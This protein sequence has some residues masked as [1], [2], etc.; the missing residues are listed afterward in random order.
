MVV[1]STNPRPTGSEPT[2]RIHG[3]KKMLEPSDKAT[4][5]V[6]YAELIKVPI[7]QWLIFSP[8]SL[9]SV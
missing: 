2:P 4:F 8:V 9:Y 3:G 6:Y 7:R 1:D 5:C